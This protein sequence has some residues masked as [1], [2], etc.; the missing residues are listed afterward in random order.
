MEGPAG[1]KLNC[2]FDPLRFPYA[3]RNATGGVVPRGRPVAVPM[4]HGQPD[5]RLC[6]FNAS[7][8]GSA[9]AGGGSGAVNACCEETAFVEHATANVFL[10]PLVTFLCGFLASRV[11][12]GRYKTKWGVTGRMG[13]AAATDQGTRIPNT[14]T[15]TASSCWRIFLIVLVALIYFASIMAV[16]A[17]AV[18]MPQQI[19]A[20]LPPADRSAQLAMQSFLAPV[21]EIFAFLED[22]MTVKV[23]YAVAA[24]NYSELNALLHIGV[25]GGAVSGVAAFLLM[26]WVAFYNTTAEAVLNPSHASNQQLIDDGC[27]LVPT[28]A[29]LLAHAR[30][31]WV[32]LT[33]AW[34]PNFAAKSVFGF[35]VGAGHLAP[36]MFAMIVQATVP[37]GLWFTL[38]DRMRPLTA[39]GWSYGTQD[40]VLAAIF[41]AYFCA[42]SSLRRTYRLRCMVCRC[43]CGGG[44]GGRGAAKGEQD[45]T[46]VAPD[47][48]ANAKPAGAASTTSWTKVLRDV[49]AGG[50]ML[51][52][53]DLSVQLSITGSIYAAAS[54]NLATGYKLAAAQAAYWSFGPSYLVGTNMLLKIIGSRLMGRGETRKYLLHLLYGVGISVSVAIGAIFLGVYAGQGMAWDFGETACE[55]A[56]QG[57]ACGRIYAAIFMGTDSLGVLMSSVLGPTVAMQLMFMVVRASLA[58]CHD[59]SFMAKASAA[60]FVVGFTPSIVYAHF[61]A[62]TATAYF[63]AMYVP[64]G[65]MILVFG[66]RLWQHGKAILAGRPG[67]WSTHS[68]TMARRRTESGSTSSAGAA[69]DSLLNNARH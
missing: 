29:H 56:G 69:T 64:H 26:V 10:P 27:A 4:P 16:V 7:S 54:Q 6:L 8:C 25:I 41:F 20:S 47:S 34:I 53:V 59:F 3:Y 48:D 1:T 23:G 61:V 32:L 58:T 44:G 63:L 19:Q 24:M 18:I 65:L 21:Q 67:P 43:G 49:V 30:T 60:C 39:L 68:E 31:Y 51:M 28:T 40:W 13:F 33:L 35:L 45:N 52:V 15:A 36:M 5:A 14:T 37:I 50:L 57:E 2:T 38:K 62:R 42:S 66:W 12:V 9:D 17:E 55:Y 46:A 22:T 11:L